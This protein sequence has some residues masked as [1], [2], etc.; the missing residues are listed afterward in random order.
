MTTVQIKSGSITNKIL[1]FVTLSKPRITC[2]VVL[3]AWAGFALGVKG[4][5]SYSLML[6]TLLATALL[7]GGVAALNQY[8]ER[9]R[10]RLMRRTA[11]RPLPTGKLS[12]RQ[13]LLFAFG[14]IILAELIF[15]V[16]VNWWSAMLGALVV[17]TYDWIYTPLK[18]HAWSS[19]LIGAVPGALPAVIGWLAAHGTW[20]APAFIL[21]SIVFLWQLP[22]VLAIATLH[23]AGY[24]QAGINLLPVGDRECALTSWEMVLVNLLLLPVSLLPAV[25]GM[26]GKPYIVPAIVL[27]ILYLCGTVGLALNPTK[28]MAGRLLRL[29]VVYLPLLLAAMVICRKGL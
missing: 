25:F 13:A 21:F 16:L 22:H 23:R 7:S 2:L 19:T 10:D 11:S 28:L 4:G 17:V 3:N 12:P 9:D 24:N 1:G 20:G 29:S 8:L 5:W 18:G 6:W 27:G 26:S 15:V 14:L